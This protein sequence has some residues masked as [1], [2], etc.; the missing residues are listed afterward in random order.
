MRMPRRLSVAVFSFTVGASCSEANRST[1]AAARADA[2]AIDT[3]ADASDAMALDTS[4]DASDAMALDTG[5]HDADSRDAE[6]ADFGF[7]DS[8]RPIDT[9]EFF[10]I[11]DGTPLDGS[12]CP[13]HPDYQTG[14]C[15]VGCYLVT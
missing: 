12:R 3:G 6:I 8:G 15:P 11:A 1:D 13:F 2:T 5:T 4:A 10:C 7:D 9:S 14:M